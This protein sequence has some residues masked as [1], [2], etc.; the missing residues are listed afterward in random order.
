[1]Y[2]LP[3]QWK[4]FFLR[5]FNWRIFDGEVW[6]VW[7]FSDDLHPF[8]TVYSS[9]PAKSSWQRTINHWST[10]FTIFSS[11]WTTLKYFSTA[12]LNL[13]WCDSTTVFYRCV[14][15]LALNKSHSILF[16]SLIQ[17]FFSLIMVY[18]IY[19][20]LTYVS[21]SRVNPHMIYPLSRYNSSI[22][23]PI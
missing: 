22:N 1:M 19:I 17:C 12:L 16:P 14:K 10:P 21:K 9:V 18:C 7:A 8:L 11:L 20:L 15:K 6:G 3:I 4:C 23:L 5:V 13:F 2:P